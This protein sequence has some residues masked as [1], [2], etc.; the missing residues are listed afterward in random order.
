M[1]ALNYLNS[2]GLADKAFFGPEPE[3]FLFDDVRYNSGEGSSFYSVDTIEAPWNSGRVEEGG[4]LGYKIQLKE[5]YFP[6]PPNDTAQDMRSEM[7]LMMGELGIPIEKHHHEVA[8]AGQHE[9]GMKFDSLIKSADSVMTYKYVC[10]L[11]TS[12]SP[13]DS[14]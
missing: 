4:N 8:G 11:Y 5:G 2:T 1:R 13:R 6:V 7:L 3:F 10:L 9:L 12:P 14:V